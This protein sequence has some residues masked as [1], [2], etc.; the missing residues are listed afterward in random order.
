MTVRVRDNCRCQQSWSMSPPSLFRIFAENPQFCVF[1]SPSILHDSISYFAFC[2]IPTP[3]SKEDSNEESEVDTCSP[4]GGKQFEMG[5]AGSHVTLKVS[6]FCL[7]D[8]LVCYVIIYANIYI[9]IYICVCVCAYI[10]IYI[11][12]YFFLIFFIF[13]IIFLFFVITSTTAMQLLFCSS[14]KTIYYRLIN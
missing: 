8:I 9:Y 11:Y 7:Y 13:Y 10:Y 1:F 4:L 2:F 3:T 5:H 12:I 6:V 14:Q